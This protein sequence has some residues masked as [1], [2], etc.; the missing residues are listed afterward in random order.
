MT[1]FRLSNNCW[2]ILIAALTLLSASLL[3]AD[4]GSRWRALTT[5]QAA[6]LGISIKPGLFRGTYQIPLLGVSPGS[7]LSAA[8]AA[9]G[10]TLEFDRY[11]DSRRRF[12]VGETVGLTLTHAGVSR[13]LDV[14]AAAVEFKPAFYWDYWGGFIIT[15]VSLFFGLLVI[16]NRPESTAYRALAMSFALSGLNFI[17]NGIGQPHLHTLGLFLWYATLPLAPFCFTVFA[18][19]FAA[20]RANAGLKA[21]FA[22]WSLAL[23]G[24]FTVALAAYGA[25]FGSGH[26]APMIGELTT[27]HQALTSVL[28]VAA[29][30]KGCRASVGD[31]RQR[32]MWMLA[33]FVMVSLVGVAGYVEITF[34]YDFMGKV[35]G[36]AVSLLM[37][38]A[39]SAIWNVVLLYAL[40]RHRIFNF[41]FAIN[42]AIFYSVLSLFMLVSF[43]VVER[44]S[45]HFLHF[46]GRSANVLLDGGVA[47]AVY[48]G[49]HRLRHSVEHWMERIFFGTWHR[50]EDALRQFVG[51]AAHITSPQVLLREFGAELKRFSGGAE[52][53]IFLHDG[54]GNYA[55]AAGS[56]HAIK[57]LDV[58]D[59]ICVR[60]RAHPAPL[61]VGEL[62]CA[63]RAE[64]ALPMSHRSDLQGIVL[65]GMKATGESYRPDELAVLGFAAHQIGL[66]HH[67]L[68][69]EKYARD[70]A[71]QQV[72]IAEL[73]EMVLATARRENPS[74]ENVIA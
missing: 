8:G 19:S 46:E 27:L 12:A 3:L 14:Q 26:D 21:A 48:L 35:N 2:K 23:L 62:Q 53:I 51:R 74:P 33:T 24:G 4:L 67:A 42:R 50:N 56:E 68:K 49:F 25:W 73:R 7:S 60:L 32:Q 39:V 34:F 57:S 40:L 64:L 29:L 37:Q 59:P 11:Q 72:Q 61:V 16:L 38:L 18:F 55:S 54:N 36:I 71:R 20:E 65:M 9:I 44:L 13:H 5:G 28:S 31:S 15:I 66:D 47:L 41:G 63:G 52:C 69:V 45:D 58:D 10:D 22:P 30:W 70:N 1:P 17:T 6:T 43:G